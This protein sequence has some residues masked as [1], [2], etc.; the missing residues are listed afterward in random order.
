MNRG[1]GGRLRVN[2]IED[3]SGGPHMYE[4]TPSFEQGIVVH[5]DVLFQGLEMRVE[6]G[7]SGGLGT[8]PYDLCRD[9]GVVD[10]VD[11]L[12]HELFEAGLGM[13]YVEVVVSYHFI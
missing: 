2:I 10:C 5:P 13:Q 9:S 4:M 1:T 11:M 12:I 3:A 6:C 8:E 7:A